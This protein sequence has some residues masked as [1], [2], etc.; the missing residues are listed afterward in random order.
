[1]PDLGKAWGGKP[2]RLLLVHVGHLPYDA[3]GA[4]PLYD[5]QGM[6]N[7]EARAVKQC[8]CGI[9]SERAVNTGAA[10]RD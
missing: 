5:M 8:Q 7:Q 10:L 1:M 4:G 2:L 6:T 9:C 3:S